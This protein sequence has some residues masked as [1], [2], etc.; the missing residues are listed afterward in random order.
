ML[1]WILAALL[2]AMPCE[3]GTAYLVRFHGFP[4]IPDHI[5]GMYPFDQNVP[6]SDP[7]FTFAGGVA[8]F[9]GLDGESYT[10]GPFVLFPAGSK[11]DRYQLTGFIL[12]ADLAPGT[13]VP[14]HFQTDG[15]LAW[16]GVPIPV[17][18]DQHWGYQA[19]RWNGA[20][21][22]VTEVLPGEVSG[23]HLEL[24]G[25]REVWISHVEVP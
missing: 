6:V 23:A 21:L 10:Y 20:T 9:G 13:P 15:K 17:F 4:D 11:Y 25:K 14:V 8:K 24:P 2:I 18:D 19:P 16:H 12:C 7:E 5:V 1:K 22:T 3:A